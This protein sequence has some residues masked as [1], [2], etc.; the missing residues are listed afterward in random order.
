MGVDR[1]EVLHSRCLQVFPQEPVLYNLLTLRLCE[2]EQK[3]RSIDSKQSIGHEAATSASGRVVE[4]R[5]TFTFPPQ[6]LARCPFSRYPLPVP[7][8]PVD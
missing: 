1:Y 8:T 4:A 5:F 6:F 3:S 7:P 2:I